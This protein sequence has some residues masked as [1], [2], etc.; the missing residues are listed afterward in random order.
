MTKKEV[1]RYCGLVCCIVRMQAL[2]G[3][4]VRE[5]VVSGASKALSVGMHFGKVQFKF[6]VMQLYFVSICLVLK[7][8]HPVWLHVITHTNVITIQRTP[9]AFSFN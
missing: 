5:D 6:Y 9:F 8:M 1:V 4:L 2:T 3:S 7:C